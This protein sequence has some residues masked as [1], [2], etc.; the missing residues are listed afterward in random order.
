MP[1]ANGGQQCDRDP[2]FEQ[3]QRSARPRGFGGARGVLA[4]STPRGAGRRGLALV[5]ASETRLS[6]SVSFGLLGRTSVPG[7]PCPTGGLRPGQPR[8]TP[9]RTRRSMIPA[10]ATSRARSSSSASACSSCPSWLAPHPSLAASV[11]PAPSLLG[12]PYLGGCAFV[13]GRRPPARRGDLVADTDRRARPARARSDRVRGR[14][15]R[16]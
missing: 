8:C 14:R 4:S 12:W 7:Y 11:T 13:F 1:C 9:C 10:A 15:R 16:S 6:G 3:R 2:A 5:K